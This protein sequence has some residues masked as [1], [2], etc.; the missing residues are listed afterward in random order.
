ESFFKRSLENYYSF[1]NLTNIG[2]PL[3]SSLLK[4]ELTPN[5]IYKNV[6]HRKLLISNRKLLEKNFPCNVDVMNITKLWD[7]VETFKPQDGKYIVTTSSGI[8]IT[9]KKI[10]LCSG[11]INTRQILINSGYLNDEPFYATDSKFGRIGRLRFSLSLPFGF[12]H[13]HLISKSIRFKTGFE[14]KGDRDVM[15]FLQ[16]AIKGISATDIH[17]L[18]EFLTLKSDFSMK[19]IL[20]FLSKPKAVLQILLME[21]SFLKNTTDFDVYCIGDFGKSLYTNN[22]DKNLFEVSLPGYDDNIVQAYKT[23]VDYLKITSDVVPIDH[24]INHP[25]LRN[26]ES[27]LHMCGSVAYNIDI[28]F[29]KESRLFYLSEDPNII[30]NDN[31]I[32]TDKGIAN[33]SIQLF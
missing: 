10:A 32:V 13:H 4:R 20:S 33:P 1:S 7:E 21:F 23:F 16:P 30:I 2:N 31:S 19:N 9:A 15:F 11:V 28:S 12:F 14:I 5:N 8:P 22:K 27:A 6:Y 29:D 26:L 3:V 24:E 17:L 18:K 25:L